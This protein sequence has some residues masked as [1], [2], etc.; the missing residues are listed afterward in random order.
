MLW[1][2][3]EPFRSAQFAHLRSIGATN[4][5]TDAL[6]LSPKATG[7]SDDYVAKPAD[8]SVDLPLSLIAHSGRA[9]LAARHSSQIAR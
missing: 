4:G 1:G 8:S 9:A 3:V 2:S 5:A 6:L 7:R